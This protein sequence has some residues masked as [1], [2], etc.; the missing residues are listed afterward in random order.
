[1]PVVLG[2]V[3]VFVPR[4]A[5]A[6]SF[7]TA[8]PE[9]AASLESGEVAVALRETEGSNV[10]EGCAL[11]VIEAP[12]EQVFAVLDD[13]ARFGEFM[14]HVQ[15]SEVEPGDDG[16]VLN[17][18]VLD[19]PFPIRNRHYTIRLETNHSE[20][21]P[22]RLEIAWTYVPGS[23]NVEENEGTWTLLRLS[24]NRTLAVY[25]VYTDPGGLIPKWALN[26][27]T[28]RTLPE[29]IEAIRRRVAD[30]FSEAAP[31]SSVEPAGR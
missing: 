28:R 23:G 20:E 25:R 6:G 4:A 1:M 5:P 26:R 14:P 19:L 24:A 9:A 13:P 2:L 3:S 31:T 8:S 12:L 22:D 15:V 10:K 27:V 18:Q 30:L 17:H 7:C 29:V 16:D 11:G 21:H